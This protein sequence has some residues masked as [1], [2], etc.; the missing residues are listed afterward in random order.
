MTNKAKL[1]I[2]SLFI[3]LINII[4][5]WITESNFIRHLGHDVILYV[6]SYYIFFIIGVIIT[7]NVKKRWICAF[8][9]P[10]LS[11]FLAFQM[12]YFWSY[13]Q[14]NKWAYLLNNFLDH[15]IISSFA[16]YIVSNGWLATLLLLAL[17]FLF[18]WGSMQ[19][20]KGK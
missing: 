13:Y 5:F 1:L 9:I 18:K 16:P 19:F 7:L 8:L 6:C 14:S 4:H 3:I 10:Y 2:Y 17:E 12:I 20:S 15:L 11:A